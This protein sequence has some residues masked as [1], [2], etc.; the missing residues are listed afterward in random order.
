MAI[1]ISRPHRSW[2]FPCGVTWRVNYTG[3]TQ[4]QLK[5]S[6][7]TLEPKLESLVF[8]CCRKRSLM[9]DRMIGCLAASRGHVECKY[10]KE[11]IYVNPCIIASKCCL[12]FNC[13]SINI[14]CNRPNLVLQTL[15][16]ER[17]FSINSININSIEF[18][19]YWNQLCWMFWI[20]FK[21]FSVNNFFHKHRCIVFNSCQQMLTLV[22]LELSIIRSVNE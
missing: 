4:P 16:T 18:V 12:T 11:S 14:K 6:R 17:V 9:L 1:Q 10:Y 8:Q 22:L 13:C 15:S 5:T 3:I 20:W 2:F 21:G 7:Q 19:H